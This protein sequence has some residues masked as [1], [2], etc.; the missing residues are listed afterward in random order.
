MVRHLRGERGKKE[1]SRIHWSTFGS[2]EYDKVTVKKSSYSFS[3]SESCRDK[4][5]Q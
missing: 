2:M 1:E 4:T 3:Y 5:G